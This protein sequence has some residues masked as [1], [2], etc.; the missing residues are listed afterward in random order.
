MFDLV[1]FAEVKSLDFSVALLLLLKKF[2]PKDRLALQ[3][4]YSRIYLNKHDIRWI[5]K[6]AFD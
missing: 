6:L 2:V 3:I 1:E 5:Q 4:K